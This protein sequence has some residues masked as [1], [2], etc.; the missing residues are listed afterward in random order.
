MRP[1]PEMDA[2]ESFGTSMRRG[3]FMDALPEEEQ[4]QITLIISPD[5]GAQVIEDTGADMGGEM[6]LDEEMG[7]PDAE[8]VG[9]LN[10]E[11]EENELARR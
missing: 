3:R 9:E 10:E 11:P 5:G 7:E 6:P 4:R 2:L 8:Q 1:D